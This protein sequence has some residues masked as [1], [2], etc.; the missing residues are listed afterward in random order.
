M[1]SLLWLM[2]GAWLFNL[3]SESPS[4]FLKSWY[5][6]L[7][8]IIYHNLIFLQPV[9]FFKQKGNEVN[10]AH[11]INNFNRVAAWV[12]IAI[13]SEIKLV[14]RANALE[15]FIKLAWVCDFIYAYFF[16]SF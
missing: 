12:P 14:H 10:V 7:I 5:E 15:R 8:I 6:N 4:C 2:N 16:Y 1:V 13:L 11:M 9:E 3:L